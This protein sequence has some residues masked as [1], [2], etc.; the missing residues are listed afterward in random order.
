ML[1]KFPTFEV[2]LQIPLLK[3]LTS[4]DKDEI[5]LGSFFLLALLLLLGTCLSSLW[6]PPFPS[7]TP[8]LISL[9]SRRGAA[10]AHLDSFPCDLVI[11]IDGSV[12]FPFGKGGFGVFANC[13]LCGTE[14][15]LSFSAGPVCLGFSAEACAI[16]QALCWS[17]HHEQVCHF[18][19]LVLSDSR[20]V[21]ATLSSPPSLLLPQSLWQELSSLSS[22]TIRLQWD[23]RFS[24]RTTRLMS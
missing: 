12:P 5:L 18:S 15:T 7:R 16:L 21:I 2:R 24:Q 23:T 17:R 13:S 19:F 1:K 10:L 11:W 14:V 22:C 20:S 9:L 4:N 6:S 3:K 8:A